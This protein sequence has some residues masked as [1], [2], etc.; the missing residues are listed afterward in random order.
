MGLE[1]G[2][3]ENSLGSQQGMYLVGGGRH[4]DRSHLP[5]APFQDPCPFLGQP[6]ALGEAPEQVPQ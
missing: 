5:R 1:E 3:T 6:Q 2:D 4:L